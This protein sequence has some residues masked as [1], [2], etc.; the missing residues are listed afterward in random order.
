MSFTTY[1]RGR[2]AFETP[3]GSPPLQKRAGI[4]RMTSLQQIPPAPLCERGVCGISF[5]KRACGTHHLKNFSPL[6]KRRVSPFCKEGTRGIL[7]NELHLIN[8]PCPPHKKG[9]ITMRG[10]TLLELLVAI[11]IFALVAVMAYGGLNTVIKQSA[12][13]EDQ[14]DQLNAMQN[15]LRQMRSDLT[16]A[17]DR[18]ARDALG[19]EVPEFA[20]GG[21]NLLTLTRMGASNPWAAAEPQLA[22][23]RWRLENGNLERA[24]F[25]PPDGAVGNS[26][27]PPDWRI[28]LRNISKIQLTFYD[29]NNQSMLD[30]PPI[31]QPSAGLPKAVEVSLTVNNLP[32][33]RMT[34]AMVSDW[35]EAAPAN[36]PSGSNN[37][38][39]APTSPQNQAEAERR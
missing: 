1:H 23:V 24:T 21:L 29:Q 28:I 27:E 19:G 31:N 36:P 30:W 12:I 3:K 18:L 22:L 4:L 38:A 34:V 37:G 39:Q 5:V 9:C 17:V 10:F 35:P 6:L 8:S 16:F 2:V 13:V 26:A 15:G 25:V 14:M 32:P 7:L 20:G 33:L 11:A